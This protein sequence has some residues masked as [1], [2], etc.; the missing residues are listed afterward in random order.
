M[1][2]ILCG[3]T[4][5]P[6]VETSRLLAEAA[7]VAG[8]DVSL[9]E[10]PA[11]A[12]G[13]GGVLVHVRMGD[14][15]RSAVAPE[16]SAEVLVGFEPLEALRAAALLAP[17]AFVALNEHPAP[18]WRMR[19]GLEPP[20]RDA[21]ARL[22]ARPAR[23]VGVRAEALVRRVDGA[24]LYGLALLGLASPLLPVPRAAFE[25]ALARGGPPDLEARRHAFARGVRLFEALPRRLAARDGAVR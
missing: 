7:L 6:V 22:E 3:V 15:V 17:G 12:C 18:T 2:V 21:A 16:G 23:V 20:P 14:E 8:L 19:A 1:A 9:S 5:Q 25:A 13:Q 4:G 10:A 24:P 11:P